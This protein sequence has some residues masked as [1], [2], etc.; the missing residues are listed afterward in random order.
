MS[1]VVACTVAVPV[2]VVV[3]FVACCSTVTVAAVVVAVV[4]DRGPCPVAKLAG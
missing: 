4:L 1:A 3:A 2:E